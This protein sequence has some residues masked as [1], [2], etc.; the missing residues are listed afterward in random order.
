MNEVRERSQQVAEIEDEPIGIVIAPGVR[1]IETP[2][3]TAY[4]WSKL[5]EPDASDTLAA[6]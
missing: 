2:C 4:V 3:F 6:A 1:A 5:P